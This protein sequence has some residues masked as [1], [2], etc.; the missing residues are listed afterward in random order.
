MKSGMLRDF[1]KIPELYSSKHST[2]RKP[3]RIQLLHI[4][5]KTTDKD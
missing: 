1:N 4:Y 5:L 2:G 3:I